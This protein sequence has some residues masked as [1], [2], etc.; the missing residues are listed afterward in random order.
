[1]SDTTLG[2]ADVDAADLPDW[3]LLGTA[4][5]TRFRTGNFAAGLRLLGAI[6]EA[7]EQANHHPDLDLRYP[8]LNIRLYSHDAGGV[9]ARDVSLARTISEL[10]SEQGVSAAPSDV[11]VVE[12]ALD[13]PD[14]NAIKPFWRA[15]LGYK[16]NPHLDDELR[17]DDGAHPMLWFQASGSDE[18]RQRF[19]IDVRVPKEVAEQRIDAAVAAG[20]T[21]VDEAPTFVVLADPEGNKICICS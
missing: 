15:A 21:V 16:D 18:P 17:N 3:R 20:G 4:L 14:Y 11:E 10:A 19:H 13:T 9:T 7:A 1:M 2:Q 8:H 5:H 12:L 6:G